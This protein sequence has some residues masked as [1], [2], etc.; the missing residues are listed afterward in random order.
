MRDAEDE[1]K[2]RLNG[3]VM[4]RGSEFFSPSFLVF[5]GL[6]VVHR[7]RGRGKKEEEDPPHAVWVGACVPRRRPSICVDGDHPFPSWRSVFLSTSAA[8][9]PPLVFSLSP[10]GGH[11]LY[12]QPKTS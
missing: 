10:L 2:K 7:E 12:S 4:L 8:S 9:F 6:R 1:K 3:F 11:I 5:L